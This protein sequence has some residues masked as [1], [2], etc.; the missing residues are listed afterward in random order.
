MI[1]HKDIQK[2]KYDF[3]YKN[4][5]SEFPLKGRRYMDED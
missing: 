4:N 5:C 3:Y 1:P 2:I